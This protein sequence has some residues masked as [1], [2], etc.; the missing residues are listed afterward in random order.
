MVLT[1]MGRTRGSEPSWPE[2]SYMWELLG[3][4]LMDMASQVLILLLSYL[5]SLYQL[6][7]SNLQNF[8][9]SVNLRHAPPAHLHERCCQPLPFTMT[10]FSLLF[11]LPFVPLLVR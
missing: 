7:F 11:L 4:A 3:E 1:L 10:V 2:Y 5:S 9:P 6:S 8:S